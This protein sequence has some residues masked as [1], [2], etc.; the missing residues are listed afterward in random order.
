MGVEKNKLVVEIG[1]GRNG[2]LA[3]LVYQFNSEPC[4]LLRACGRVWQGGIR[5]ILRIMVLFVVTGH[6]LEGLG[7]EDNMS[8]RDE[9]QRD[10]NSGV[11]NRRHG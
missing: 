1:A 10:P 11:S 7:R 9:A 8:W 6:G 2:R 5:S 3:R 4:Y